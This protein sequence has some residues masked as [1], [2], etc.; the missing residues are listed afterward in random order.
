MKLYFMGVTDIKVNG[1]LRR[2]Y[3]LIPSPRIT[4]YIYEMI[5]ELR[6]CCLKAKLL[7]TFKSNPALCTDLFTKFLLPQPLAG[8]R[9]NQK[10]SSLV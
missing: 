8:R 9:F 4:V 10:H 5:F 1:F 6:T 7:V 3:L 2:S